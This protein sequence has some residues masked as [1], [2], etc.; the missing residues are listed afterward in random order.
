M[1]NSATIDIYIYNKDLSIGAWLMP[2]M[3]VCLLNAIDI[4]WAIKNEHSR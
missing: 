4:E 2:H 3:E 1:S